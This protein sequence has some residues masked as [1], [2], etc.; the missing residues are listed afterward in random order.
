MSKGRITKEQLSDSLLNFITQNA[1]TSGSGGGP[2]T[3][4][5][6]KNSTVIESST[7]RVAI[8]ISGFNKSKDLLMV[9]KNSV[10]LE[11]DVIYNITSDSLYIQKIQGNWNEFGTSIFNFVVIKGAGTASSGSDSNNSGT[12]ADGTITKAKLAIELQNK[13]DKIDTLI[14]ND[15]KLTS[16]L[17]Q[18][19][20]FVNPEM[21]GAV[22]DGVTNDY[23]SLLNCHTYANEKGLQVIYSNKNYFIATAKGIEIK[24][25]VDMSNAIITIDE[26]CYNYDNPIFRVMPSSY[27]YRDLT[28]IE[29]GKVK[30]S[31]FS[32]IK[33]YKNSFIKIDS[34]DIFCKRQ[35]SNGIDEYV[36]KKELFYVNDN[37][38][39]IGEIVQQFD[40]P[41]KITISSGENSFL[42]IKLG[43]ILLNGSQPTGINLTPVWGFLSVQ[44]SRT[45]VDG[46]NVS[47]LN[48][49]IFNGEY[50][51]NGFLRIRDTYGVI[52]R[53]IKNIARKTPSTNRGSYCLSYHESINLL[54]ENYEAF[55]NSD[56]FWGSTSGHYVKDLVFLNCKTNRIDCHSWV[57]NLSVKNSDIYNGSI[58][59]VG[60][61]KLFLENVN[62][63]HSSDDEISFLE[64]RR[65]Y[66]NYL[67]MDV[68]IKNCSLNVYSDINNVYLYNFYTDNSYDSLNSKI[69][70]KSLRIENFKFNCKNEKTVCTVIKNESS[71]Q[72]LKSYKHFLPSELY[73]DNI[74]AENN[75]LIIFDLSNLNLW[76]MINGKEWVLKNIHLKDEIDN[77]SS[78]SNVVKNIRLIGG[79]EYSENKPNFSFVCENVKNIKIALRGCGC[80]R[81]DFIRSL[82]NSFADGDGSTDDNLNCNINY[83]ECEFRN[84]S[85]SSYASSKA[86]DVTALTNFSCCYFYSPLVDG[87]AN[88]SYV[89]S[90]Y[91]LVKDNTTNYQVRGNHVMTRVDTTIR[92]S[93][94]FVKG[95]TTQ[96]NAIKVFNFGVHLTDM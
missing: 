67:D 54:I 72:G 58:Q 75:K 3:I 33:E 7:N 6:K 69:M 73:M 30:L 1:G 83:S 8:G 80:N 12:I 49:N 25:N 44:R 77:G 57:H 66:S 59:L 96:K 28:E 89:T 14:Q 2:A 62:L 4:E 74:N 84:N 95:T 88:A 32:F 65:D 10:Y 24:T 15:T 35:V 90:K 17:E 31:D 16:Q 40:K 61:G 91:F 60:T 52:L 46:M 37:G 56:Q 45:I 34:D 79:K 94:C 68:Q 43:K 85:E 48:N 38:D 42:N 93:N 5:F 51:M 50:Y 86:I 87:Q 19:T 47:L 92:D 55:D 64:S 82:I 9:Y 76:N 81:V 11:E 27:V 53:N 23:E 26:S 29:K 78:N 18:I 36:Y 20:N 13:I 71:V 22:G 63:F 70:C 39:I 41:T 21:F